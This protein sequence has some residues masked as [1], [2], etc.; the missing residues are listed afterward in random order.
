MPVGMA[1]DFNTH[2]TSTATNIATPANVPGQAAQQ[3][4]LPNL[5]G[6][7]LEYASIT[8]NDTK[9]KSFTLPMKLN[10]I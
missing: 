5:V 6:A 9:V 3:E 1:T 10:T 2:F 7:G 4:K 8:Q